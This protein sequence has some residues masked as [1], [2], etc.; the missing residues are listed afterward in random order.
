MRLHAYLIVRTGG[1]VMKSQRL[2][3]RTALVGI[4]LSVGAAA[5]SKLARAGEAP[6]LDPKDPQAAKLGYVEAAAQVDLKKFPTYA[7]GQTCENCLQLEGAS[8]APY[9]PCTVFPGKTV[10][11]AGWCSSWTPEI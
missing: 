11:A 3:R 1:Q 7:K 4:G 8:G 6:H 2:S 9:R 10:A 5:F